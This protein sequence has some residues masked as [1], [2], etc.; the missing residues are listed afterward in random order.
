MAI[1]GVRV[2]SVFGVALARRGSL[3]GGG[4]SRRRGSRGCS[5]AAAFAALMS[6]RMA[7]VGAAP[8]TAF[9]LA[10]AV[11]L[12]D[13]CPGAPFRFLLGNATLF[14]TFRDVVG[15]AFLFVCVFRFVA[16]GHVRV[17]SGDIKE[18]KNRPASSS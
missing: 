3:F 16:A 6:G 10:A 7:C 11:I 18:T 13:R 9:L 15:L 4:R 8:R 12:V 2:V 1:S 5:F 17:L 14:I